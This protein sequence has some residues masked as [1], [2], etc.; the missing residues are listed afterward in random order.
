MLSSK[1]TLRTFFR[2]Q[3]HA[4]CDN[5]PQERSRAEEILCSR[6]RSWPQAPLWGVFAALEDE[7]NLWPFF[8][9]RLNQE[10]PTALPRLEGDHL[11]FYS[12][13]LNTP[14]TPNQWGI[15]EPPSAAVSLL[16][17]ILLVPL[18]ACDERGTRLGQGKGFYDRFLKALRAQKPC[19]ALGV[20]FDCQVTTVLPTDPWDEPL[21][22]LETPSGARSFGGR[23][24]ELFVK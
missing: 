1:K 2:E 20:A 6:F 3:R 12:W 15:P 17:D 8:K 18:L 21:D 13:T 11:S 7:P 19:I 10:L 16:P 22:F 24:L 14:L 23:N 4:W 5:F 9:E